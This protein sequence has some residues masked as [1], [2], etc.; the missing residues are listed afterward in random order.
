MGKEYRFQPQNVCSRE[1]IIRV[2]EEGIIES[3]EVVGGCHGNLQG[4][5][6]LVQG[7]NVDEVSSLLKGI[8]CRGSRNKITSCPDQLAHFLSSLS[9]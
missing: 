3:L 5:A 2:S 7:R 9:K 4:I 1:M 8:A 6:R